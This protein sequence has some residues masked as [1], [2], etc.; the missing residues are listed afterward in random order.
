ML[1]LQAAPVQVV[2]IETPA[3][4]VADVGSHVE[5]VQLARAGDVINMSEE[6]FASLFVNP[7]GFVH[8]MVTL[9]K[10]YPHSLYNTSMHACN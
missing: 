2:G 10:V 5:H 9:R 6:G 8:D 4:A 7:H 1:G 3:S